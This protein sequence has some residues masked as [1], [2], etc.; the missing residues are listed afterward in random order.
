MMRMTYKPRTHHRDGYGFGDTV[1]MMMR[2]NGRDLLDRATAAQPYTTPQHEAT[3]YVHRAP[4][5]RKLTD[6][7]VAEQRHYAALAMKYDAAR[8]AAA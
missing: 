8:K 6:V 3:K 4:I 1:G 5:A 7:E 2:C